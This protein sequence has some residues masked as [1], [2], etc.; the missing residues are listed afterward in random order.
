MEVSFYLA[1]NVV[2]EVNWIPNK[3]Y[4]GVYGLLKLTLP[5]ALPPTL[6]RA[7]VLDT[8][9]TFAT[10]IAQLWALFMRMSSSQVCTLF[11]KLKRTSN[12]HKC[13]S[14]SIAF[15]PFQF[16][17]DYTLYEVLQ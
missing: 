4:S 6:E 16:C 8:D 3:H 13:M 1:D 12:T 17:S 7:I 10:D 14:H 11:S 9:V 15:P 5:R 2:S